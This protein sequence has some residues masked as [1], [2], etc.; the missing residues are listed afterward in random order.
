MKKFD[1]YDISILQAKYYKWIIECHFNK[2]YAVDMNHNEIQPDF[3]SAL[4]GQLT[5]AIRPAHRRHQIISTQNK[6]AN[7]LDDLRSSKYLI[8]LKPKWGF[9]CS[10]KLCKFCRLQHKKPYPLGNYCPTDLFSKDP[11]KLR[12][13]LE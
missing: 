2:R 6:H 7:L 1:Q 5:K 8:E 13:A 12:R 11:L 9:N 3:I 4:N 10:E